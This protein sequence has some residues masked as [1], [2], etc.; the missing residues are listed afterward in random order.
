MIP[1]H[2]VGIRSSVRKFRRAFLGALF[3]PIAVSAVEV[4]SLHPLLTDMAREIGGDR[5][6][7]I[8][9]IG[10]ADNPHEFDPTPQTLRR[11]EGANL[12]LASGKGLESAYLDQLR[13]NLGPDQILVELGRRVHSLVAADGNP[14]PCCD[15]HTLSGVVDP[16]W[17]HEPDNMRRAARELA[18]AL[19]EVGRCEDATRVLLAVMEPLP[20]DAPT[21]I[22]AQKLLDGLRKRHE[23]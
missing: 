1:F 21:R 2:R 16:H 4:A 10:A 3:L 22:K 6:T 23:D 19:S 20:A 5:V 17:W 12:F 8:E 9:L 18:E 13:E 14:A 15:H 7:V 11:A